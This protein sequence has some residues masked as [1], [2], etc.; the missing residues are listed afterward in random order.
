M[1]KSFIPSMYIPSIYQIN[2]Q[3]LRRRGINSIIV[4]LDNTLVES[5]RPDATPKLINWLKELKENQFKVIIVSN[6]SKARVSKFATPLDIPFIYTA[7]KP[8][9]TA[10]RKALKKLKC[11]REQTAVIGDQ[12]FT[13]VLGGNRM[14]MYTILVVPVSKSEGTVTRF[15]RRLER[16]IF[17][18][19]KKK[20]YLG[21]EDDH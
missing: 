3:E 17:R 15:N 21:L 1:Y 8:L 19:L 7:R 6:N 10:F 16:Y 13:D 12:L 11:A 2:I 9:S 4:D 14:G 5:T 20:G 18:W